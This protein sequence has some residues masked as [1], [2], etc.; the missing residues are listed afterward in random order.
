MMDAA[1]PSAGPS[2]VASDTTPDCS[3][4]SSASEDDGGR[5]VIVI[6]CG[7]AAWGAL[8]TLQGWVAGGGKLVHLPNSKT[9]TNDATLDKTATLLL[10]HTSDAPVVRVD[11]PSKVVHT[12]AGPLSFEKL[13]ICDGVGPDQQTFLF[14]PWLERRG[15][16]GPG[17]GK[18]GASAEGTAAT[19]G[20]KPS[21][22]ILLTDAA[23]VHR[24]LASYIKMGR[25]GVVKQMEQQALA[26]QQR[27]CVDTRKLSTVSYNYKPPVPAAGA[28]ASEQ[29]GHDE[30]TDASH[31]SVFC[32]ED[33]SGTDDEVSSESD[34][35]S[36][37]T[38]PPIF[39]VDVYVPPKTNDNVELYLSA[40]KEREADAELQADAKLASLRL[41][42]MPGPDTPLHLD[43][44]LSALY[45]CLSVV[46]LSRQKVSAAALSLV[47]TIPTLRSLSLARCD[48]ARQALLP[49]LSDILTTGV[50]SLSLRSLD[51]SGILLAEEAAEAATST[52]YARSC[53]EVIGAACC[54]GLELLTMRNCGI[55]C[56]ILSAMDFRHTTPPTPRATGDLLRSVSIRGKVNRRPEPLEQRRF[57][58]RH[59]DLSHNPLNDEGVSHL[60]HRSGMF[61]QGEDVPGKGR[62]KETAAQHADLADVAHA[63][64]RPS[65]ALDCLVLQDVGLKVVN[66]DPDAELRHGHPR[67]P[68][69]RVQALHAAGIELHTFSW[70][71]KLD[72]SHNALRTVSVPYAGL[73]CCEN[74]DVSSVRLCPRLPERLIRDCLAAAPM[75]RYLGICGYDVGEGAL[76]T[77]GCAELANLLA[78]HRHLALVSV[79]LAQSSY[80]R[81]MSVLNS[82]AKETKMVYNDVTNDA[83]RYLRGVVS[84][85]QEDWTAMFGQAAAADLLQHA[86][87]THT[88]PAADDRRRGTFQPGACGGRAQA[89]PA[90]CRM[91]THITE[92]AG[93]ISRVLP[94]EGACDSLGC[95]V[96]VRR[97]PSEP[98]PGNVEGPFGACPAGGGA[99][100]RPSESSASLPEQLAAS[101]HTRHQELSSFFSGGFPGHGRDV[102][103]LSEDEWR[104][105]LAGC[106]TPYHVVLALARQFGGLGPSD[107]AR[108]PAKPHVSC[109][110]R[111]LQGTVRR[112]VHGDSLS[113]DVAQ[114]QLDAAAA[115]SDAAGQ[116]LPTEDEIGVV[117]RV[118]TD[119]AMLADRVI[120]GERAGRQE[121]RCKQYAVRRS[122]PAYRVCSTPDEADCIEVHAYDPHP[123]RLTRWDVRGAP[124]FATRALL[125]TGG[126]CRS[127]VLVTG[128]ENAVL[129]EASDALLCPP[130]DG[131][132]GVVPGCSGDVVAAGGCNAARSG[133]VVSDVHR[134]CE[135]QAGCRSAELQGVEAGLYVLGDAV[136]SLVPSFRT[137]EAKTRSAS[138][139]AQSPRTYLAHHR[140]PDL[141][142]ELVKTVLD[143]PP[144]TARERR[145]GILRGRIVEDAAQS[146]HASALPL[147][148][149]SEGA[150]GRNP[151]EGSDKAAT[152]P[153]APR[154]DQR[155]AAKSRRT[156]KR[157]REQNRVAY[158]MH[159]RL[160]EVEETGL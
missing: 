116:R 114:A 138:Q 44:M 111:S 28:P 30:A 97:F 74:L 105:A 99:R 121:A 50:S 42:S 16:R 98:S 39:F 108:A 159:K 3:S 29:D 52:A 92:A 118:F 40:E 89:T 127:N 64:N 120:Q 60:L 10:S 48:V 91:Q 75:L 100:S 82:C 135:P 18:R 86:E 46:D 21:L 12:S 8:Q 102:C 133:L 14:P 155:A 55:T 103:N 153:A 87:A 51:L 68:G 33:S 160:W 96:Q 20:S 156:F 31:S 63:V 7:P 5:T 57:T 78:H 128:A 6:G 35:D 151:E 136:E 72:L 143:L 90:A 140:V 49:G 66:L 122:D 113:Q 56:G 27:K 150:P 65:A 88:S 149:A 11:V 126:A 38:I 123:G 104:A 148:H 94:A 54:Y 4:V 77:Y 71:K 61:A 157:L 24:K 132:G 84:V 58:L 15:R 95:I 130:R 26:R 158:L 32:G 101:C 109:H 93:W 146:L 1:R 79:S 85:V 129:F 119:N 124:P 117:F 41:G 147:Y 73:L 110:M 83:R 154:T 112:S 67:L 144:I 37:V 134:C 23:D 17:L 107:P 69:G 139:Q 80:D 125:T 13:V 36:D 106:P 2:D 9:D 19:A 47:S 62:T 34:E 76:N 141:V 25:R 137:L 142:E 70:L 131:W 115:A 152:N 59:L 43:A 22:H 53:A 81:N 45:P 145:Q